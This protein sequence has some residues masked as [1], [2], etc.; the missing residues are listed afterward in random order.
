MKILKRFAP[1]GFAIALISSPALAADRAVYFPF[2]EAVAAAKA[3]GKI[4]GTVRFY[5]AGKSPQGQILR[6]EVVVNKKTNA[7]K[8]NDATACQHVVQSAVIALHKAAKKAGANAV[9]NIVSYYKKV[10][11]NDGVNYECHAGGV[12]AGVALKGDLVKLR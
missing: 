6:R 12:I 5:L 9:T 4:D 11:H 2:T 7:F 3:S 10:E 8:K 1:L